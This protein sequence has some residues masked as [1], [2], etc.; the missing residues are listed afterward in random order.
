MCLGLKD[1]ATPRHAGSY[2]H[3][4][5]SLHLQGLFTHPHITPTDGN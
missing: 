1:S 3:P 4:C 2:P 5:C